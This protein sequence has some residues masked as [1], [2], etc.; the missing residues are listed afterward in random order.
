MGIVAVIAPILCYILQQ[1]SERW[2]GGY[3]FSYELLLVN[4]LITF[5]GLVLLI[6]REKK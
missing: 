4:A 2:F 6:K 1:N 5:I 3:K